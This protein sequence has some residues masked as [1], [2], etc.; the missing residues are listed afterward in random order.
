MKKL[1]TKEIKKLNELKSI[2]KLLKIIDILRNPLNGCPWDLKQDYMSLSDYPIEES[3]E[4][5]NAIEN[6][7]I[8]NIKEELGDLL[9]QIVLLS[10]IG[11][12]N[13]DFEFNDVVENTIEKMIRR[14]PQ[15]F[16]K[17]YKNKDLPQDTWEQIKLEEKKIKN[18]VFFNSVLNEIPKNFP[19]FLRSYKVQ[20]KVSAKYNFDWDN[21][22]KVL[23]KIDEELIELKLALK[24]LDKIDNIEEEIGDLI[25]TTI[26]LIRH[27]K[28]NPDKVLRKSLKKF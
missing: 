22:E 1:S 19:P 13:N 17:N 18:N 12:E 9:L 7:D 11:K 25:F 21:H 5:Q 8:N 3:Y 14:H 15:I 20:K 27:L 26:N 2:D 24:N 16:D 28:L 10:Q 23:K 4:L 6:K